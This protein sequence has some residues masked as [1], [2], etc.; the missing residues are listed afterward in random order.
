M[1]TSYLGLMTGSVS[2]QVGTE[3]GILMRELRAL[4]WVL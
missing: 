1:C 3:L 2:G 4:R